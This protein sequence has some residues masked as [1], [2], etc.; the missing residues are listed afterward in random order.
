MYQSTAKQQQRLCICRGV[1]HALKKKEE[2]YR[3]KIQIDKR[4]FWMPLNFFNNHKNI[5]LNYQILL[6]RH[7]FISL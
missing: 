3:K 5:G 7:S 6:Q 1:Y 4:V 2:E